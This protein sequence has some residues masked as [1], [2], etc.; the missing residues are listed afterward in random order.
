MES[1]KF[2]RG[3]LGHLYRAILITV[4]LSALTHLTLIFVAFIETHNVEL[5]NPVVFL[6]F[7]TVTPQYIHS[8]LAVGLGWTALILTGSL[9]FL[10]RSKRILRQFMHKQIRQGRRWANRG[11]LG[12]LLWIERELEIEVESDS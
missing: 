3:L 1:M 9:I 2:V 7:D 8:P 12:I 11:M 6:G 10:Y 5:I 4:V